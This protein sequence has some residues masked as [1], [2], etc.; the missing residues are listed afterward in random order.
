MGNG[1]TGR[2]GTPGRH[3]ANGA[4]DTY[5]T[6]ETYRRVV[7]LTGAALPAVSFLARL[8]TATIQFGSVLLVARTSGSLATAGLVGGA[9]AVGQVA[10][11]PL[12]GRLADRHGQRTVVLTFSLVNALAI[13]A[14]VTGAVARLAPLPLALLGTLAGASVPP[15]GRWPAPAWSPWPAARERTS[16]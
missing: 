6:L 2:L 7:A 16:A 1:N 5:G 10:C 3:D 12:V 11:G 9:L 13:T 4:P 15:S 14:L 8:P